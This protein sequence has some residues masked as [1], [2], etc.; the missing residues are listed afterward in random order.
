MD[1]LFGDPFYHNIIHHLNMR[2]I[3]MLKCVCQHYN[4]K[5]S[6]TFI[7]KMTMSYIKDDL[8]KVFNDNYVEFKNELKNAEWSELHQINKE[9]LIQNY[10]KYFVIIIFKKPSK[11]FIINSYICENIFIFNN[12]Y[13]APG[14]FYQISYSGKSILYCDVIRNDTN[15]APIKEIIY[16]KKSNYHS[17]TYWVEHDSQELFNLADYL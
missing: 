3:H 4:T 16:N 2:E 6:K 5:I 7:K 1:I 13:H 10:N 8:K 17:N 12:N 11:N 9:E 14:E 15:I